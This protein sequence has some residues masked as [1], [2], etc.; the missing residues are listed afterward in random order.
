[1]GKTLMRPRKILSLHCIC[2]I[3]SQTTV[4]R[5]AVETAARTG[6]PPISQS[7][8]HALTR[9]PGEDSPGF[10][11]PPTRRYDLSYTHYDAS[12]HLGLIAPHACPSALRPPPDGPAQSSRPSVR[13]SVHPSVRPPVR[14][15]VRP[16]ARPSVRPPAR[17]S[18]RPASSPGHR[19]TRPRTSLAPRRRETD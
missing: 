6:V 13:P 5:A 9:D 15:S 11:A 12:L 8:C 7:D 19:I 2:L 4:S 1:M 17:P 16:P 14:P 3:T 10:P 18:V